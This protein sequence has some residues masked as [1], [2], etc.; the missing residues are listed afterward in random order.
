VLPKKSLTKEQAL[1]K[2][3]HYCS[4]QERCHNEVKTK[5]YQLG[6]NK[7]LNDEIIAELI[8]GSYLNEE[9]FAI[10]FATGKFKINHWGKRKIEYAL[11]EKFISNYCIKKAL[12]QIPEKEYLAILGKLANEKYKDLKGEQYL[13]RKR[14]TI[15]YLLGKGFEW[16]LVSK[17]V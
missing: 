15:D 17:I 4:Y 5:L 14:K 1:Q 2:L 9:R 8:Q 3:R 16:E 13:I 6:T 11:K 12:Q 7:K 10:A